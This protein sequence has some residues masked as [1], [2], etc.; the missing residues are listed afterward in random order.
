MLLLLSVKNEKIVSLDLELRK[1]ANWHAFGYW[2]SDTEDKSGRQVENFARPPISVT[3]KQ[4][5]SVIN[6]LD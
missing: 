1:V 3:S 4:I 6:K 5:E 2:F